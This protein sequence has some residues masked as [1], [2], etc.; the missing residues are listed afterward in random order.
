MRLARGSG[1]IAPGGPFQAAIGDAVDIG[2]GAADVEDQAVAQDF[3]EQLGA[4]QHRAGRGQ[5]A[6][7]GQL[8]QCGPCP[9]R[10]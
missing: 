3:G 5:D 2:G 8:C 10:G 7:V 6:P 4:A 9:G 1:S